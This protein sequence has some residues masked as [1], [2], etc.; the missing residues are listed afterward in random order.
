MIV[1]NDE[2]T[3]KIIKTCFEVS[4][5]I[6]SGFIEQVYQNALLIALLQKG[7]EAESEVAYAVHFRGK[8]VGQ[9][10]ADIVVENR[11]I[12]ELKAV[13]L[14]TNEHQAQ[15]I[16]YLKA[17]GLDIGLLI[18]FGKPRCEVKRLFRNP[19]QMDTPKT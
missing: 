14:L 3:E 7:I 2:L 5:E 6:G 16:N 18:N 8:L 12:L 19:L 1:Q 17:S 10:S 15:L 13:S 9:F 11:V 4:N